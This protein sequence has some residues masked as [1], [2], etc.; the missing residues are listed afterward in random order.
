M[1]TVNT[2]NG[3]K[4]EM[5]LVDTFERGKLFY[6]QNRLCLTDNDNNEVNKLDVLSFV[7]EVK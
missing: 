7:E 1:E 5:L 3:L 4:I 2:K 6:A